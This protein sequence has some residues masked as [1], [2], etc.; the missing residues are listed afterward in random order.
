MISTVPRTE[1]RSNNAATARYQTPMAR[2]IAW[3][4]PLAVGLKQAFAPDMATPQIE[5]HHAAHAEDIGRD[6]LGLPQSPG[7]QPLERRE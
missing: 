3:R 7:A 6:L 2:R 1:R 5:H 4:K